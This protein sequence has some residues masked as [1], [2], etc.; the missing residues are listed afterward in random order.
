M[1]SHRVNVPFAESYQ[2]ITDMTSSVRPFSGKSFLASRD[3]DGE[4]EVD[5]SM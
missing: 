1:Y 2:T 3:I 5:N 4:Q